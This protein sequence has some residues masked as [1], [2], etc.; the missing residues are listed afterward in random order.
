MSDNR[1]K[2]IEIAET[3]VRSGGYNGFSFR[4]IAAQIGIK[5]SSVHYYFPTKE[6]LALEVAERYT[7]DFFA[8]LGDPNSANGA[9]PEKLR[10]YCSVFQS[11]FE[12]SGRACLCGMLS[13]EVA[14]LP[15]SVRLAVIEF[16][17][18]N[19]SWLKNTLSPATGDN[20]T[21]AAKTIY[22]GLEGALS[23]A[24]LTKDA[25]WIEDVASSTL[26]SILGEE[27]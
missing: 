23:A 10:H 16:V 14:L 6:A 9:T 12:S 25:S 2:I 3:M 26:A 7:T 15:E 24:A 13:N 18:A 27:G 20:K 19:I 1:T 21:S 17:N 4:E 5:S 11:A 8:A 22:C